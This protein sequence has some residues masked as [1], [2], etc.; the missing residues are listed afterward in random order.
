V[1]AMLIA[2]ERLEGLE[3]L[4]AALILIAAVAEARGDGK[5]SNT[6]AAA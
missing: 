4:G 5:S 3:W 1:S 2:G 6:Q